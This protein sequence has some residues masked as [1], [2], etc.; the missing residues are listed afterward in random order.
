VSRWAG[1]RSSPTLVAAPAL[2]DAAHEQRRRFR[3]PF[4]SHD[5]RRGISRHRRV[6]AAALAGLAVI[7]ATDAAVAAASSTADE[8]TVLA[9]AHD[10]ASGTELT[11]SDIEQ[12]VLPAS[13]VPDGTLRDQ[14]AVVGRTT[15][16]ALR[17]GEPLTDVRID[18]G[19]LRTPEAGLV[20]APVRLA[21]A[22]AAALLRPGEHIDVL[23]A[24]TSA[25]DPPDA[26]TVVASD[27]R[28]LD[29]TTPPA[30]A[31]ADSFDEGALVV[32]ATTPVQA[33]ALAQAQVSAR[34]SAVVVQ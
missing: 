14:T 20:A 31:N 16:G 28:V 5:L 12:V 22:Q 3:Q 34:L 17:R 11:A 30:T 7:A 21:D 19:P 1:L 13:A 9:A 15:A 2:A 23:A 10:I 29:V 18:D 24:S 8:V 6:I 25:T 33:R 32:L 27:V 26:A 4:S